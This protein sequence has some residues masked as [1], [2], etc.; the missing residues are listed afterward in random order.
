[1]SPVQVE[2]VKHEHLKW[3]AVDFLA[4]PIL[5]LFDGLLHALTGVGSGKSLQDKVTQARQAYTA[6]NKTAT[7]SA[8]SALT[9]ELTAQAGK[10]LPQSTAT[11]RR[12]DTAVIAAALSCP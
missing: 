11:A 7:C 2:G 5:Q 3:R 9:K 6:Q 8:L 4:T 1:M 12:N 10:K